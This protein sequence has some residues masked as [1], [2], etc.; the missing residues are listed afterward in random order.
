MTLSPTDTSTGMRSP[1][2]SLK[3]PGPTATTS[4]SCGFSLAVSG[5]TRPDA[6]VSSASSGLTTIRSSRGLML[7]DT[8]V[9]L[10]FPGVGFGLRDVFGC[11]W[12]WH[13]HL[14]S[15][16]SETSTQPQ[17]VPDEGGRGMSEFPPE[18]HAERATPTADDAAPS[19]AASDR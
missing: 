18:R 8:F 9:D 7:T 19:D 17:R 3:R 6:V 15:A 2:V 16:N 1:P 12:R 13:T 11:D 5:M 4:P 10:H 14:E